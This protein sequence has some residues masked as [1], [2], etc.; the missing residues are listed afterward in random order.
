MIVKT[1][2][3][4]RCN[5]AVPAGRDCRHVII[6]VNINIKE[7]KDSKVPKDSKEVPKK[8]AKNA[9]LSYMLILLEGVVTLN[10]KFNQYLR[11]R[12]AH[13]GDWPPT[14]DPVDPLT[15]TDI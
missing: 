4:N 10:E 6:D 14:V 9:N 13:T 8:S 2:P 15:D 7:S 1:H 11:F 12:P 5:F 3:E